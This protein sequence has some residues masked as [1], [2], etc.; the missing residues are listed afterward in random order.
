MV[1]VMGPCTFTDLDGRPDSKEHE[2][3]WST[4]VEPYIEATSA[5]YWKNDKDISYVPENFKW[6]SKVVW[7]VYDI[8]PFMGYRFKEMCKKIAAVYAAK[9]YTY[10]FQVFMNQFDSKDGRDFG[11]EVDFNN[12]AF[13]DRDDNFRKDYEEI[14][15]EGS[16]QQLLNEYRDVVISS[17][18]EVVELVPEMSG[19]TN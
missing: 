12:W 16:F 13:F 4:N 19:A 5:E 18:D 8:K 15:G 1:W 2:D 10:N 7:T 11:I 3:D 17:V 14:N 9:K 6:G